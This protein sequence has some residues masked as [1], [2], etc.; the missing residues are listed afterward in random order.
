MRSIA[1]QRSGR[2]GSG[3]KM[4]FEPVMY[5]TGDEGYAVIQLVAHVT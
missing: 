5:T 2:A 4:N 1:L 3:H